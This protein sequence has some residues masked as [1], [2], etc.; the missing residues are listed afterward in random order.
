MGAQPG[1]GGCTEGREGGDGG[2]VGGRWGG[3][4]VREE[5]VVWEG[6]DE[7]KDEEK[8]RTKMRI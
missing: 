3:E 2:G 1:G 5:E 6:G 8:G 4:V 7:G